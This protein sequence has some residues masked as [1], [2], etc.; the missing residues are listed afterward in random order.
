MPGA[1]IFPKKT[2]RGAGK[3]AWEG[4]GE[5]RRPNL[6]DTGDVEFGGVQSETGVH[7]TEDQDG[8]DIGKI[9]NESPDLEARQG[10]GVGMGMNGVGMGM[11]GVEMGIYGV[12]REL[13]GWEG[14]LMWWE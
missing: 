9:S 14:Q 12:G 11:N 10:N 13:M 7:S 4:R 5:G 1:A 8:E 6:D 3:R 2:W